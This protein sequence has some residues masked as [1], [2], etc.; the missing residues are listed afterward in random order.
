MFHGQFPSCEDVAERVEIESDDAPPRSQ[1]IRRRRRFDRLLDG[2]IMRGG[3]R[4]DEILHFLNRLFHG[5]I[6]RV[7]EVIESGIGGL[8]MGEGGGGGS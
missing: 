6:K 5:R 2:R 8:T 7:D 3:G 4:G 1:I